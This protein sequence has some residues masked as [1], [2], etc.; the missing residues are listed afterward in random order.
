MGVR[1]GDGGFGASAQQYGQAVRR[2][3][4]NALGVTVALDA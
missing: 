2:C 1:A 4:G 3:I